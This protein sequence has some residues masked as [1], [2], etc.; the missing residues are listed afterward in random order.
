MKHGLNLQRTAVAQTTA[1]V[2][3]PWSFGDVVT[4]TAWDSSDKIDSRQVDGPKFM[5]KYWESI[6]LL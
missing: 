5:D 6:L 2:P 3:M 4:M 1:M